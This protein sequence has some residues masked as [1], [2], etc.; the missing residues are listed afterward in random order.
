MLADGGH[1]I[2]QGAAAT[3]VHMHV[4]AGHCRD[5]Q[6]GGQR[7]QFMKALRIVR[8]AMQFHTQPQAAGEQLAQP[9]DVDFLLRQPDGEQAIQRL[10]E[11][12]PQQAVAALVGAATG[13]GDQPAE[14]LVAGE[15]FHQQHELGAGLDLHLAADDQRHAAFLRRLPGADDAGQAAF[16]GDRQ[17]AVAQH[18]GADEQLLRTGGATLEAEVA[19]AVQFG[20]IGAHANQPCSSNGPSSP[21]AR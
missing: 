5:F 12:A 10:V 16:V 3:G 17:G 9:A 14:V 13:V 15:V 7:L 19:Q 20:V 1:A 18:F 4:A 2:L 6:A 21:T 11:V 8:A